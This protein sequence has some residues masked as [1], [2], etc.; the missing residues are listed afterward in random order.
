M[1]GRPDY[2]EAAD[3]QYERERLQRDRIARDELRDHLAEQHGVFYSHREWA[4][5]TLDDLERAHDHARQATD[6]YPEGSSV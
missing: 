3:Q 1:T 2:V 5:V 4:Q 6:C